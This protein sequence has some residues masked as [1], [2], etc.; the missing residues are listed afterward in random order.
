MWHF[1]CDKIHRYV[2][3]LIT[4]S[5][6][7]F[8]SAPIKFYLVLQ[9][10]PATRYIVIKTPIFVSFWK[11]NILLTIKLVMYIVMNDLMIFFGC[12]KNLKYLFQT[13]FIIAMPKKKT[14]KKWCLSMVRFYWRK[15]E[16]WMKNKTTTTSHLLPIT[17]MLYFN[18]HIFFL[19]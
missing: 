15:K 11:K 8:S 4:V 14:D 3:S 18:C 6:F 13:R 1:V 16:F 9:I 2:W 5:I 10:I 19:F 12:V 7:C 17:T